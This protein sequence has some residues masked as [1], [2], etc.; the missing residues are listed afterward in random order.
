MICMQVWQWPEWG[1]P[2]GGVHPAHHPGAGPCSITAPTCGLAL[3]APA[4]SEYPLLHHI[5]QA[6]LCDFMRSR[7]SDRASYPRTGQPERL[8]RRP[9][10]CVWVLSL[11]LGH[12]TALQPTLELGQA[13]AGLICLLTLLLALSNRGLLSIPE[14][15]S[16][17]LRL[18]RGWQAVTTFQ[19]T[20]RSRWGF[21]R[22][23][24]ASPGP[25]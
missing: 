11:G 21:R 23:L 16:T 1:S 20:L 8:W 15:D 18:A 3:D 9:E 4:R 6:H 19:P 2:E 5:Y 25:S 7:L 22:I 10:S 14:A 17:Q 24:L 12:G 13:I